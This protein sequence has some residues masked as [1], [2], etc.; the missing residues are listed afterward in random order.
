MLE[1]Q[2]TQLRKYI[3]TNFGLNF[4][5]S[6]ENELYKKIGLAAKEFNYKN[7]DAFINRIVNNHIDPK[8]VEKLAAFLTVG[9]TYFF[10][11]TKALEYFEYEYL[12]KLLYKRRG[13]DKR[14]RIWSAGCASGEE[15]YSLAII[16]QRAIPDIK[17]WDILILAT[18]INTNFLKKAKAG[19]YTK[20]SFR[21]TSELIKKD[22]FKEIG[23]ERFSLN[24]KI[25]KMVT[26]S[27]QNLAIDNYPSLVSNTNAMDIIFCRNVLIYFSNSKI[28]EVTSRLYN[29][30]VNDGIL[31]VSPVETSN[32]ISQK[33]NLIQ[34]QGI[35]IYEKDKSK[36]K[37]DE[38]IVSDWKIPIRKKSPVEKQTPKLTKLNTHETRNA[39]HKTRI[40]IAIVTKPEIQPTELSI[41]EKAYA[42]FTTGLFEEAETIL[43]DT[44]NSN[45]K[46]IKPNILLLARIKANMGKL[47]EAEQLCKKA[48]KIDK[49]DPGAYYLLA[50][51]Q[52]EYGKEKDALACLN[53]SLF[54]DPDFTLAYF[55]LG[56]YSVKSN[57]MAQSR[58]YFNNALSTLSKL[59][60]DAVLAEADGLTVGRLTE[61]INTMKE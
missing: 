53:T 56:T 25:K 42:F 10:R 49:L 54:L 44:I 22:H 11:E 3:L 50:I 37:K 19:N 2:L 35:T 9:E 57:K 39:K 18:D 47:D 34:Y 38:K 48:I 27:Y 20:W 43:S 5:Q 29:S 4:I 45:K 30:L 32:L 12:P 21:E 51:V 13:K 23:N 28:K 58:K 26:F 59:E 55:L 1:I 24:S 52:S 46:N 33:Y 41:Y 15:P 14:I 40:P 36:T 61:I 6:R 31:L 7:T 8:Q 16:L 17:N 60:S